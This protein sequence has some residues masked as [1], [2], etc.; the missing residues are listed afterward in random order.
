MDRLLDLS[1]ADKVSRDPDGIRYRVID[2][3]LKTFHRLLGK[4]ESIR[5]SYESEIDS[6]M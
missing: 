3:G 5:M 4:L 2:C 6:T 1:V